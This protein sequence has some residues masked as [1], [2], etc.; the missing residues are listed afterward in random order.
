[1]SLGEDVWEGVSKRLCFCSDASDP[2]EMYERYEAVLDAVGADDEL[3]E[4][5]YFRTALELMAGPGAG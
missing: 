3:R 1:M 5:V 4:R 2:V